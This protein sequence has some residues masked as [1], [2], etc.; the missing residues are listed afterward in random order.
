MYEANDGLIA[1]TV[2]FYEH[3]LAPG[4]SDSSNT[5]FG[6]LTIAP[7]AQDN[8]YVP[9]TNSVINANDFASA[10]TAQVGQGFLVRA[11]EGETGQLVFNNT[12]RVNTNSNFVRASENLQTNSENNSSLFRLQ[13]TS[14]TANINEAVVGFYDYASNENDIMDT[15]SLGAPIY[16]LNQNKRLAV[17]GRALPLDQTAVIPMGYNAG[18]EGEFTVSISETKGIFDSAQYVILFDSELQVYHNLSLTPYVF[19]TTVGRNEVRFQLIFVM[20]LSSGDFEAQMSQVAVW[21]VQDQLNIKSL[22]Q[23]DLKEVIIYDLMGRI[24]YQQEVASASHSIHDL[25]PTESII[26]VKTTLANGT[27]ATQKVKF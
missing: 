10:E 20:A 12:M 1:N 2:Y 25:K 18:V 9:A 5:N 16:T 14:P 22:G 6:V 15:Q 7:D 21:T 19:N 17:Q 11:I 24:I 23:E 4:V 8:V 26:I 3:T 27:I 13:L